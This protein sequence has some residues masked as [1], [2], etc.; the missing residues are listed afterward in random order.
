MIQIGDLVPNVY[1]Q[2]MNTSGPEKIN[3]RKWFE[4]QRI[5]LFALPG[6]FTP[7][8]SARH[9]PGYLEKSAQFKSKGVDAIACLSVNDAY[10]MEAWRIDQG[11]TGEIQMLADG[12]GSFTSAA[13][14]D[15]DLSRSG[16]GI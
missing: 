7:T 14:L 11:I 10:V 2:T 1:I 13:G 12:S 4:G 3:A 16:Y 8:C 6:A 5:V 15:Q 9:V